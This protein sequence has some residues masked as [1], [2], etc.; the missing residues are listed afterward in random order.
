MD[1]KS[2]G[3]ATETLEELR[4]IKD[5]QTKECLFSLAKTSNLS[6]S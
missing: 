4:E 2:S 5:S 1:S 6:Q 3:L